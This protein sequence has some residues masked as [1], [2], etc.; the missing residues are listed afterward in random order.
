M[1]SSSDTVNFPVKV[2]QIKGKGE[3]SACKNKVHTVFRDYKKTRK[4]MNDTF[5]KNYPFL[6]FFIISR[7]LHTSLI[8]S[9]FELLA[10][11]ILRAPYFTYKKSSHQ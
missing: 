10:K 9:Q 2:G 3:R 1:I 7:T 5:R 11:E 4:K 8:T 6:F